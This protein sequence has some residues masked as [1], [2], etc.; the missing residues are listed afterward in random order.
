MTD[1]NRFLG[2][3][4]TGIGKQYD[5]SEFANNNLSGDAVIDRFINMAGAK[6]VKPFDTDGNHISAGYEFDKIVDG[7][8]G[9]ATSAQACENIWLCVPNINIP[10]S[11]KNI[12][13]DDLDENGKVKYK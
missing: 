3:P 11:I 1:F 10:D 4:I 5:V 6:A 8:S 7:D 2:T 13:G 9:F 12:G